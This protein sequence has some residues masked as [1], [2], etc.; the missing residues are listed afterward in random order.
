VRAQLR[1]VIPFAVVAGVACT[2]ASLAAQAFTAPQGVGAVTVASQIVDN[3]GH[4]LSDGFFLARGQSKTASALF[5]VEYGVTDRL[6][7]TFGLP[8]VFAKYTGT[9]PPISG[10]PI[11]TCRCWQSSFQDFS[12]SARYRSGT[13]VWAIT[14]IAR[15]GLPSHDYPYAG[16]AV[17]GK[18]L[19]EFQIGLNAGLRLADLLPKATLQAGYTYAFVER[20]IPDVDLDR[21]NGYLDFGYALTRRVYVRGNGVWQRTHGGL[22][23]GSPTGNP[24]F[25][26]GE[27]NTPERYSQRDRL[28]RVNYWQAGG[29]VSYSL[30]PIDVFASY[31]KYIWG[32][33]AHNGQAYTFGTSWYFDLR[34]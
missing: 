20:A 8:Y 30:G 16:E 31:L 34:E 15:Y 2:P 14:P 17:V 24:F 11:D 3:T 9:T 33:D 19:H 12:F 21:S 26:P 1:A 6:S 28:L 13:D 7:A 22:R 4:R 10:L 29:G 27:L 5:E 25:P 23:F 32:H 18:N